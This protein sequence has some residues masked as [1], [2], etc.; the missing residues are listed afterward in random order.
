[1]QP[2]ALAEALKAEG[3]IAFAKQFYRAAIDR[4]TEALTLCPEWAVLLV[5]RAICHKLKSPAD[6]DA[7]QRDTEK[8]LELDPQNMKVLPQLRMHLQGA[9][10][11]RSSPAS[12]LPEHA[13]A[14]R[15]PLQ[16]A[17]RV[18]RR[19]PVVER[20]VSKSLGMQAH[21]FLGE[22]LLEQETD[23]AGS[24][25]HL[26]KVCQCVGDCPMTLHEGVVSSIEHR[27]Q[28]A[29]GTGSG[30]GSGGQIRHQRPDLE[31]S[32]ARK[33][34]LSGLTMRIP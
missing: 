11:D 19:L 33:V 16:P 8:A 2:R 34:T 27:L 14:P 20:V 18:H 28:S 17:E 7:V 23:L 3:N 24:L 29:S 26:T 6:W 30:V 5:N 4:Y 21:L 12:A 10:R 32:G 25:A 9:C 31:K 13:G 15:P 1:M 22:S